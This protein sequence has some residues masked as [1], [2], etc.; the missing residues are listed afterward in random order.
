[1][2]SPTSPNFIITTHSPVYVNS[3]QH[4]PAYQTKKITPF[5]PT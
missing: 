4:Q 2:T 3:Q 5:C 1:M